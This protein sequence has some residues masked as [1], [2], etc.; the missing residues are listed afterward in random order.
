LPLFNIVY[1]WGS[2]HHTG[3]MWKG[4]RIIAR[5][6][7]PGRGLLVLGIY[8]RKLIVSDVMRRIKRAYSRSGPLG[9]HAIKWPYWLAT[10]GYRFIRRSGTPWGDIRTYPRKR[11]MDYWTDLDDW[12]GGYPFECAKPEAVSGFVR[13]L[14]FTVE[15]RK[16]S[17]SMASVNEFVFRRA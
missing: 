16:L 13:G 11:G 8:N 15:S 7:A 9:K 17:T 5:R 1:A 14:G 10:V 6:C 2:L 4:I 3:D 12:L